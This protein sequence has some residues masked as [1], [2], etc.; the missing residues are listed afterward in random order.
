LVI[1]AIFV[2]MRHSQQNKTHCL[3]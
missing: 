3:F 2:M 1:L